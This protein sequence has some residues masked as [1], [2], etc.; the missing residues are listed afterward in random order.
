M[1]NSKDHKNYQDGTN[2][3]NH[4]NININIS[5]NLNTHKIPKALLGK[6]VNN[7]AHKIKAA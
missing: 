7:K 5:Y 2:S 1:H 4:Q 3:N 6:K